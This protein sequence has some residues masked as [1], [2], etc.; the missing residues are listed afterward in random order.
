M[1]TTKIEVGDVVE[2]LFGRG[3]KNIEEVVDVSQDKKVVF[4]LSSIKKLK[5]GQPVERVNRHWKPAK[6]TK[7]RKPLTRRRQRGR[8]VITAT[9]IVLTQDPK[10]PSLR[11]FC[12]VEV[13]DQMSVTGFEISE[14]PKNGIVVAF[15]AGVRLIPANSK[16]WIAWRGR[17]VEDYLKLTTTKGGR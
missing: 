8:L 16:A 12:C 2:T 3:Y 4:T 14:T 15:P 5:M 1:V 13:S 11:A 10:K 9:S 6:A 7:P 17:I